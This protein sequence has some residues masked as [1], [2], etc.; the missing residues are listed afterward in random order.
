MPCISYKVGG[1]AAVPTAIFIE[2]AD[3]YSCGSTHPAVKHIA[4][5]R[6]NKFKQ[7]QIVAVKMRKLPYNRR[8]NPFLI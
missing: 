5:C 1:A 3:G 2:A 8:R 7:V 6:Y 4:I